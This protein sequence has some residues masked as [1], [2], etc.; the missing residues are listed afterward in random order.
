[1]ADYAADQ[2]VELALEHRVVGDLGARGH[3]DQHQGDAP[4]V[5]RVGFE[6]TLEAE[7]ALEDALGVIE[8][9][10]A[11]HDV[12]RA[13]GAADALRAFLDAWARC[14]RGE[15]IGR[16]AEREDAHPHRAAMGGD[17]VARAVD[18][19]SQDAL[20]AVEEL[21]N[22]GARVEADQVGAEHPLEQFRAPGKDPE[23]LFR[24]ERDVPEEPDRNT[25]TL[26][27]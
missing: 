9:I 15:I 20:A 6:E 21:D 25:W 1:M 17:L 10:Y 11:E 14:K 4:M 27:A 12:R 23:N 13:Q 2:L 3:R 7:Q 8:P 22:V 18:A 24:G 19:Q 5:G 16:D 26:L